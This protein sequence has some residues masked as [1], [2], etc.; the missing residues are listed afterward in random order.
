MF[1]CYLNTVEYRATSGATR[2]SSRASMEL[3]VKPNF[4]K[5]YRSVTFTHNFHPDSGTVT[6]SSTSVDL[7]MS[8]E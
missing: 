4:T 1:E 3:Y 7:M 5:D 2:E 6:L 8:F